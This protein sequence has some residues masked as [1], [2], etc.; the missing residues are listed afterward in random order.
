M[1]RT[2]IVVLA[3]VFGIGARAVRAAPDE[4]SAAPV[5]ATGAALVS[6]PA[7]SE[8]SAPPAAHGARSADAAFTRDQQADA[9]LHACLQLAQTPGTPAAVRACF[10]DVATS[11]ADTLAATRAAASVTLLDAQAIAASVGAA[12]S[13]GPPP[14]LA[15][16]R[17]ELVGVSGI[18]GV[19]NAIAGG[20]VVGLQLPNANGGVLFLGTSAAALGLGVGAGV[21]GYFLGEA[22]S[23]SE[24]DA[25]VTASGLL[26]GTNL[27][28]ALQGALMPTLFPLGGNTSTSLSLG[29]VVAGGWTVGL[30]GLASTR[31]AHLDGPQV[32]LL[33]S[34]GI[35]GSFLGGMVLVNLA[36]R[37]VQGNWPYALTYMGGNVAGLAAGYAL[38][39]VLDLSWGETLI[40]DL[41]MV[42]GGVVTSTATAGTLLLIGGNADGVV[43]GTI[44]TSAASMGVVGGY[45]AGLAV[46]SAL[47]GAKKAVWRT[48]LDGVVLEPAALAVFDRRG[49]ALPAAGFRARF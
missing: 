33:N 39:R 7:S 19:W 48:A 22:L 40:G 45:A 26:W 30:L 2:C 32:S 16:G 21:G 47:R 9:A 34:G 12:P 31:F 36:T 1:K 42:L 6:D 13:D 4:P 18:F 25:R 38:G 15:P 8:V 14:L 3:L 35:M 10:A 5:E 29:T 49:L 46:V 41:G 43:V 28:I 24:G 17:I 44:I 23:L 11:F 20:I 27:G 37:N